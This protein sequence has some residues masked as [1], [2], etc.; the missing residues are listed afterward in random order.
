LKTDKVLEIVLEFK[1]SI[2][3]NIAFNYHF[4]ANTYMHFTSTCF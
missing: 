3:W 4:K 2:C 1:S